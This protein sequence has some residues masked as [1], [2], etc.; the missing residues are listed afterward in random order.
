MSL[1]NHEFILIPLIPIQHHKVRF[2]LSCEYT[3]KA[4]SDME[5]TAK[6]T[7]QKPP[8]RPIALGSHGYPSE[9]HII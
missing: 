7:L 6:P 3:G 8:V 9:V 5:M 1:S 2:S 4:T